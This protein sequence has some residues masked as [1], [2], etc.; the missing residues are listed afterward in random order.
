MRE[1]QRGV[2]GNGALSVHNLR[3]PVRGHI[4]IARE[5]RSAH[6]ERLKLFG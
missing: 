4:E 6:A 2:D 5:F 1:A 3:D